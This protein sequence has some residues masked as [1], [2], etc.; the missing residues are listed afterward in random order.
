MRNN[1]ILVVSTDEELDQLASDL[2]DAAANDVEVKI[3]VN[4]NTYFV[5]AE[6]VIVPQL[7]FAPRK[8]ELSNEPVLLNS[9]AFSFDAQR[10]VILS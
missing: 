9:G 10:T 2:A 4:G 6:H 7:Y 5:S 3:E 1:L 8:A